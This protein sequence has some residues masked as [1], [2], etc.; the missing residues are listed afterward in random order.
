M[1]VEETLS[2]IAYV[3]SGFFLLIIFWYSKLSSIS[4]CFQMMHTVL[5]KFSNFKMLSISIPSNSSTSNNFFDRV[6]FLFHQNVTYFKNRHEK[7]RKINICERTVL[8]FIPY[9][10]INKKQCESK[11]QK[12]IG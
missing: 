3:T 2:P 9:S 6:V 12:M 1:L 7:M 8:Y 5:A 4:D 11:Y 10:Y